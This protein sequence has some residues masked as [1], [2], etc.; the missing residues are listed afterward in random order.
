MISK[1]VLCIAIALLAVTASGTMAATTNADNF[2]VSQLS[3][4][5]DS[6]LNLQASNSY[7]IVTGDTINPTPTPYATVLG[8]V[9]TG[10]AGGAWNGNGINSSKAASDPNMVSAL[11]IVNATDANAWGAISSFHGHT[12]LD[13]DS[14]IGYTTYGDS[15]L[16]G[17]VNGDDYFYID[18]AFLN[19]GAT[20]GYSG[21]LWGDY[22]YNG[23]TNGDDY[24]WI[25]WVFLNGYTPAAASAGAVSAVS[26]VP[27]PSTVILLVSSALCAFVVYLR[28]R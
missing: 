6:S 21:W 3:I 1:R 25:D 20:A 7:G 24:F 16:D 10:Y 26:A 15:N 12:P 23:E 14:L 17:T 22:D 19:G 11:G 28:K 27:E 18:W 5:A 4:A 13:G 8:Y 2:I 9:T